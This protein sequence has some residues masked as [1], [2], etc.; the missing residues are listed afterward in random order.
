MPN[1]NIETALKEVYAL[2]PSHV[3][4]LD[5]LE[6]SH[7]SLGEVI[8]IVRDPEDFTAK[9]ETGEEVTFEASAFRFIPP[10]SG[11]NGFQALTIAI[12]NVDRRVS[13]FVEAVGTESREPVE[14]K[15]RPY[16]SNDASGPQQNPPL[17]L[18]LT[19]LKI[20]AFEVTGQA[21]FVGIANLPYPNEYYDRERFKGLGG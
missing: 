16:L 7:P 4:V 1:D 2:A 11:A 15:Y 12:D 18:F 10:A 13:D 8:R 21:T 6:I 9:L 20:T 14:V 5:T 19:D 3:V 17:V